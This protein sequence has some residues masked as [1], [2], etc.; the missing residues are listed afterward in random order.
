MRTARLAVFLALACSSQAAASPWPAVH[1]AP[2]KEVR[3]TVFFSTRQA[4]R[5][6][7]HGEEGGGDRLTFDASDRGRGQSLAAELRLD[8]GGVPLLVHVTG[9]DYWKNPV[10]DRFERK[11]G[12]AAWSNASEHGEATP[13]GPAFYLT[14]ET[15]L[16][17]GILAA[18]LLRAEGGHLHLLPEGEARIEPAGEAKVTAGAQ[19]QTLHL[20]ANLRPRFH[21]G[22]RVDGRAGPLLRAVR[23]IRLSAVRE[24]WE[25]ALPSLVAAQGKVASAWEKGLAVRLARRPKGDLAIRGARLFD[26]ETGK[27]LAGTTVIVSGDRI[28]AVGKDGEVPV[29]AGAEIIEAGA[30]PSF[31]ACGTCTSTWWRATACWT[32]PPASPRPA[33]WAT[34]STSCWIFAAA[35][36]P[37]KPSGRAC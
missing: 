17:I 22:L 20:Y 23:R 8:D 11:A 4:G 28:R 2:G 7:L 35:G 3:Y 13:A 5:V 1:L 18:A 34:I 31:P 24:G 26:P 12:R 29:P 37:A 6:V 33:T 30:R 36:M 9:V 21:A 16:E 14:T 15:D 32:S 10:D 25:S 19:S 27:S